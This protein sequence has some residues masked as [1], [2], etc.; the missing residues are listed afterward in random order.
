MRADPSDPC[1][2][3]GVL[4]PASARLSDGSLYVYPRLVAE[5]NYSRIGRAKVQWRDG[6]PVGVSRDGFALEPA[7]DYEHQLRT[8]GG[9]EDPRVTFVR[10]LNR[11]V[12]TYVALGV[13]GPR[14]AIATSIDG[15]DWKRLGLARFERSLGVD[16]SSFGNKDAVMFPELVRDPHGTASLAILHR[17]TYLTPAPDGTVEKHIPEGVSDDR[18]SIWISYISL[19]RDAADLHWLLSARDTTL[20]AQPQQSWESLKI[21]AGTPPIL[22]EA[23]WILFHHGVSGHEPSALD[24][25]KN[26]CYQAGV[27]VLDRDDPREVSYRSRDPVLKPEGADESSGVVANVVFPTA[28]DAVG[29][30]IFVF[31][32]AADTRI[33][34]A[35][36]SFESRIVVAPSTAAEN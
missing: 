6:Q 19:Q 29:Q 4:N 16:F 9:V 21:G 13:S 34:V 11:Y 30:D 23:G 3:W 32:G 15:L 2:A 1:E 18:P 25:T 12:M 8:G 10:P 33:S 35:S 31:Y 27:M 24:A 36:T 7:T 26:V 28:V 20:L 22:T 14:V 5:G 17:P